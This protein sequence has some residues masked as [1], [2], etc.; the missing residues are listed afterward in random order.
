[1][2]ALDYAFRQAWTS[3]WRA[4]AATGFAVTAIGLA[5]IVLGALLLLSWNAQRVLVR[6]GDAAE[7]S[8][9]LRDDASSDQ[10]GAI[11]AA[12][13]ASGV[14]RGREYVS[15]Q[16]AAARFRSGHADLAPLA[17]GLDQTPFPASIEVR[18]DTGSAEEARVTTLVRQ[19]AKMPG[20]E[21][22]RYD[23][24]W[25]TRLGAGLR[26]LGAAG[27]TLA[28]LM[29]L[30]AATTVAAVVRLGLQNRRDE[31]EIM[32]LVGAPT[33]YIRGPFIAEG[34]LQGGF[35]ALLALLVL[36]AGFLAARAWWGSALG[37]ALEGETLQFLPLKMWVALVTG[38]MAVGAAGGFAAARHARFAD[39]AQG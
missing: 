14:A 21:D 32:E 6:L 39:V 13:D 19:M 35:G 4:R 27:L 18:L 10:R 37:A 24:E 36:W 33:A 8:I 12:L 22:V 31:I 3:L 26:A 20:V 5:L 17:E 1:M 15:K 29:G 34:L 30:A 23:R 9:Y 7:F 28:L 38:G 11:E 25:L 16:Q 2:R